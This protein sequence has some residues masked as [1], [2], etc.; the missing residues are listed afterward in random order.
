MFQ[1]AAAAPALLGLSFI[2]AAERRA[3]DLRE[4]DGGWPFKLNPV[5]EA[6]FE[7]GSAWGVPMW[8]DDA[9]D[10]RSARGFRA[11]GWEFEGSSM[12]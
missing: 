1:P 12:W 4:R 7:A 11:E 9:R 3:G 10:T 5:A 8:C 2:G 6:D